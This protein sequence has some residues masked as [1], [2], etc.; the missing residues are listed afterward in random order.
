MTRWVK[1]V[2]VAGHGV[3]SGQAADSPF[4][5]GTIEMQAP[6][7]AQRGLDLSPFVMATVN[8]DIAPL[9]LHEPRVTLPDVRWTQVHGPETFSFVDCRVRRG[10]RTHVG[11]VYVPH[12]ETK[13]MHHQPASVIELLLPP[14]PALAP[15]E[16]LEVSLAEGQARAIARGAR[17]PSA[18][19]PMP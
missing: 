8:L 6:H 7:F 2:V 13:P 15:G 17:R 18:E 3:A 1:G 10:E 14:L 11:L 5:T 4:A 16:R 12:P 19:R 9:H